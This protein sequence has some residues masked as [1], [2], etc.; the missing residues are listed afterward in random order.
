MKEDSKRNALGE[1]KYKYWC[2]VTIQKFPILV[3]SSPACGMSETYSYQVG[4]DGSEIEGQK[5]CLSCDDVNVPE[6]KVACL[7]AS[8]KNVIEPRAVD[9]R[10]SDLVAVDAQM[11]SVLNVNRFRPIQGLHDDMATLSDFANFVNAH[12]A[13]R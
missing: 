8:L 4:G 13:P 2:H 10:D 7:K 12:S 6:A 3:K 9:L 11:A 5:S 1:V